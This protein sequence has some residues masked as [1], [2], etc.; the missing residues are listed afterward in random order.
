MLRYMVKV[1]E[2]LV[3]E[4]EKLHA[5]ALVNF[6][7][8]GERTELQWDH[9]MKGLTIFSSRL[10][11]HALDELNRLEQKDGQS[12]SECA[13]I[14]DQRIKDVATFKR[15]EPDEILER[16][17]HMLVSGAARDSVMRYQGR[18]NWLVHNLS[19]A[20]GEADT[21]YY[22]VL[23]RQ[24]NVLALSSPTDAHVPHIAYHT[25]RHAAATALVTSVSIQAV[26]TLAPVHTAECT[27]CGLD[28]HTKDEYWVRWPYLAEGYAHA[29]T[30]RPARHLMPLWEKYVREYGCEDIVGFHSSRANNHFP[31]P[32]TPEN[33][34]QQ[35]TKGYSA[36][37]T[38]PA[39]RIVAIV[40]NKEDGSWGACALR[41]DEPLNHIACAGRGV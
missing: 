40:S 29:H 18:V 13:R 9:I 2:K 23:R 4:Q 39:P 34:Q 1:D 31:C 22:N 38:Q 7:D 35:R 12:P 5:E 37:F 11:M 27:F 36:R 20:A 41:Q 8:P 25:Q 28:S 33:G 21:E 19:D 6:P 10:S 32:A 15:M 26:N 24:T 17:L 30:W 3:N 16:S 14:L